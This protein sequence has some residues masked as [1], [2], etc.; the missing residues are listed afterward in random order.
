MASSECN[1]MFCAR[2]RHEVV[3]AAAAIRQLASR[4]RTVRAKCC[5]RLVGDELSNSDEMLRLMAC[6]ERFLLSFTTFACP[7][8]RLAI[9]LLA[10][11]STDDSRR[12]ADNCSMLRT[13]LTDIQMP[14]MG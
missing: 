1:A 6:S 10:R 11:I 5:C 14:L 4:E 2:S 12:A 9:V 13:V 8:P 7:H 3:L